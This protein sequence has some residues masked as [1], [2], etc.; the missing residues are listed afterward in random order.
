M[1]PFP[2]AILHTAAAKG[3]A[4]PPHSWFM[5]QGWRDVMFLHAPFDERD[6]QR[7][8]PAHLQPALFEGQGWLSIVIFRCV[9]NALRISAGIPVLPQYIEFNLRT[10]CVCDNS[11][12]IHFLQLRTASLPAR[13]GA[14]L[15]THLPYLAG[16]TVF[17]NHP[18]Q[19]RF[20]DGRGDN[21]LGV[22]FAPGAEAANSSL[23]EWLAERYYSFQGDGRGRIL[24]YDVRHTPWRLQR[25]TITDL[26]LNY[27]YGP[28]HLSPK[29]IR[30]A[31]YSSGVNAL[32][33]RG[34]PH[35]AALG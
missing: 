31:H 29:N 3:L 22:Q 15:L 16:K 12:G 1:R 4:T 32:L 8:L 20:T 17:N 5:E 27:R 7:L 24:R 23:D 33:W 14:R 6:I 18:L 13:V 21:M 34:V 26:K 19:Y 35:G 9:G 2:S 28:L 10:Y 11:E 30:C 25:A